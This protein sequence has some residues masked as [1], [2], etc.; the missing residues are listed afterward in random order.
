[1]IKTGMNTFF[2]VLRGTILPSSA[3]STFLFLRIHLIYYILLVSVVGISHSPVSGTECV[4]RKYFEV[5][6]TFGG[7][8][9][10]QNRTMKCDMYF[11][12][13]V[14]DYCCFDKFDRYEENP[15]CCYSETYKLVLAAG[16]ICLVLLA[17]TFSIFF[18]WVYNLPHHILYLFT[19]G[20]F[21]L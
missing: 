13:T 16:F 15:Y 18:C 19:C 10:N 9:V 1:M 20:K 4:K 11:Q 14:A 17:T 12:W 21:S 3:R 2:L 6:I 7:I 5:T 8:R